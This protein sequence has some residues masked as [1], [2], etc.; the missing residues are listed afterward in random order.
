MYVD[1][2]T[3]KNVSG[4]QLMSSS[5]TPKSHSLISPLE[6]NKILEGLISEK[7]GDCN[8]NIYSKIAQKYHHVMGV[9]LK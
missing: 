2:P 4:M 5:E 8:M 1:L 7:W 6:L 9:P 3:K